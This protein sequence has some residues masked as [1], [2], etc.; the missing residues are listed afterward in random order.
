M[1]ADLILLFIPTIA[2]ISFTPGLCMTLAFTLG[3]SIGY[4]RTLWMM[5]GELTGVTTVFGA[6]FWSLGWLLSRDII[7]F[8]I[9]SLIGGTYLLYLAARLFNETPEQLEA[10][11]LEN[12]RASALALLGFVTAVSNPKGWAFLLALLPGFVAADTALLPQFAIMLAIM[13]T[14]EFFSMTAY[15]TGGQWL[16]TRL[17]NSQGLL[18]ANRVAASMLGLAALWV[19]SGALN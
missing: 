4:R 15:A 17:S 3:L 1:S 18:N 8:Q 10:R 14:T 16:A 13:L 6:T 5:A 12:T 9:I 7:Y 2:A 11:N 19:L